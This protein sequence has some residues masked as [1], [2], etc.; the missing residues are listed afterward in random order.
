M[1]LNRAVTVVGSSDFEAPSCRFLRS[2]SFLDSSEYDSVY[3][4][5][6]RCALSEFIV[7]A[8]CG[9]GHIFVWVIRTF[10]TAGCRLARGR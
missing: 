6:D 4:C 1:I 8:S 3:R 5:S 2:Q 10:D 7:A 9:S